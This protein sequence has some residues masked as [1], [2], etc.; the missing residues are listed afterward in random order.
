MKSHP[1]KKLSIHTELKKK[2][3]GGQ[4]KKEGKATGKGD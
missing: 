2:K 3:G 4:K 1:I